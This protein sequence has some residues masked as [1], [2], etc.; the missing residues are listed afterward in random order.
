MRLQNQL[1]S[2]AAISSHEHLKRSHPFIKTLF[3]QI[4]QIYSFKCP[5]CFTWKTVQNASA[6]C[7]VGLVGFRHCIALQPNTWLEDGKTIK[8]HHVS[9][10]APN[11]MHFTMSDYMNCCEQAEL[12]VEHES[13]EMRGNCDFKQQQ[14]KNGKIKQRTTIEIQ[15]IIVVRAH[16]RRILLRS[17]LSGDNYL[18]I[19]LRPFHARE[20]CTPHEIEAMGKTS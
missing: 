16:N 5:I 9:E 6:S 7:L 19:S 1:K 15:I 10:E 13:I 8:S 3:A 14:Q 12:S 18:R 2:V 4:E 20:Y 17:D 11:G